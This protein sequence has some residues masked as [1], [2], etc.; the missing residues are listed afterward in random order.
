MTI[1]IT[2]RQELNKTILLLL[3]FTKYVHDIKE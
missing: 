2:T 3:L 1:N